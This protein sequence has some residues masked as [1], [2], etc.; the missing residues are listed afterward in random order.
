MGSNIVDEL[1]VTHCR[2]GE[3]DALAG[4]RIADS[5]ADLVGGTPLVRINRA[6]PSGGAEVLGKLEFTNP[7]SSIKDRTALAIVEAAEADG[8][9]QPGGTII[10][11]TSGNTGIA[12]AWIGAAK[13]YRVI[14]VM[15]DDVSEERR[16]LLRA[17]G[18]ELILSPGPRAMA[19]ANEEAGRILEDTPGAFLA[20]QGGNEANPTIHETTTGPEIW[21]DT[22]GKVDVLVATVGT[23][24]TITGAGRY[25][26]AQHPQLE[27]VAVQPR[28][29]P[30]LT[31]GVFQPHRIQGIIGGDGFP[32]VLDMGLVDQ[33][34]DISQVD[35]VRTAR[36]ALALDGLI[37][38][39]SSGAALAAAQVLSA[40]AEYAGR[41]IVA[42]L[43]DSGERYISTEL[44][45]HARGH[46]GEEPVDSRSITRSIP[47]ERGQ[48][49]LHS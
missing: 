48:H 33:V 16:A 5:A 4:R 14:I 30:V 11:A 26:K 10:E 19:G 7:A 29:A 39:V 42:I 43:P 12:L 13:G 41:T 20:G 2:R 1:T 37:V 9:L 49:D 28:E 18:A 25:L 34:I 32:P 27:V 44:F 31:G 6:L 40:R 3:S 21:R 23:G 24:G 36:R 47:E 45:D 22:A 8:R 38:G 46:V 35:A 17:L 15:P